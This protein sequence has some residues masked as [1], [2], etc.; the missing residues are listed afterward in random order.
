MPNAIFSHYKSVFLQQQ[1]FYWA[2]GL[3]ACGTRSVAEQQCVTA[4]AA[5][6]LFGSGAVYF[7]LQ[8]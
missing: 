1:F 3:C 5:H 4:A 2:Q 7:V 6:S 8:S